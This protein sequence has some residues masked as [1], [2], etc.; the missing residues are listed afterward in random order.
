[1]L[2]ASDLTRKTACAEKEL[3]KRMLNDRPVLKLKRQRDN[4][5]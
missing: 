3:P 2:A 4:H 1:M 5:G